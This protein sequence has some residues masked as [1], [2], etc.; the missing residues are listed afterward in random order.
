MK[1]VFFSDIHGN[2]Y[3]FDC[4]L[5]RMSEEKP[6][7]IVFCGDVFGYYYGQEEI[8]NKMRN[9]DNLVCILGN[10]DQYFLDVL[11]GIREE[12]EL[13]AK[14]GNT[15]MN[16]GRKIS[17]LNIQFVKNFLP[18]WFYKTNCIHIGVFHGSPED[19][20]NARIYPDTV[21]SQ[22]A[23]YNN[24]NYV[25]LGHTH[26]KMVRRIGGTTII[27]PGSLGQQRD[28]SGCSYLQM[29]IQDEVYKFHTVDYDISA[30]LLEID[31][32]DNGSNKLKEVLQ[33]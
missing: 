5:E 14:Y 30:L 31:Q 7:K 6:N 32:N 18:Y 8:L 4:F 29:E 28:G 26:H 12:T 22:Q 25:I 10:H 13:T 2:Q 11:E 1:I 20:L 3:A 27:N 23:P 24:Y 21:I 19:Y 16:V 33:R 15:Y 17:A 9:M